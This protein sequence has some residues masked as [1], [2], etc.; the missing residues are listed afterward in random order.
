M[1]KIYFIT[2]DTETTQDGLVA[3]FAAT[4]SDKKGN[5]LAECAVLVDGV[6]TEHEK[7]PLFFDSKAAPSAL[8]SK[9]GADRRYAMY[10]SMIKSGVRMIASRA[11]I[12]VWLLKAKAQFDPILTA[13]NLPFDQ[14]KCRNTGIDLAVFSKS[15][16]LWQASYALW[17]HTKKY[18]AMV[19]DTNAFNPPTNKGNMSFKTNAETM[20]RFVL[21]NP[22][23]ED[24]P[25]TA[26]EDVKFYELPILNA[27]LKTKSVRWIL[28][29][30]KPYNWRECQVKD[31]FR[32]S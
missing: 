7:H 3:D 22:A 12:N 28:E 29:N 21:G 1:K 5:V 31:W 9:A 30:S 25:H 14:G 4:V 32:P 11:A 16:C 15:F 19:L 13:Y 17:A 6:F 2:V 26:L 10:N 23:L 24:E 20:A 8:W 27:M 18:R